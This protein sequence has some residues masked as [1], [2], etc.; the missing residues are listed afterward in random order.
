MR[1]L[2]GAGAGLRMRQPR[3]EQ[4]LNAE[5]GGIQVENSRRM[6]RCSS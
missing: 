4:V 3:E 5:C 1:F 6:S 2:N